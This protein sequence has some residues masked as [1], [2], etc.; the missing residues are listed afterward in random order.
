MGNST[1]PVTG[2]LSGRAWLCKLRSDKG[3]LIDVYVKLDVNT[4]LIRET[5][6]SR[7][8][9]ADWTVATAGVIIMQS[10]TIQLTVLSLKT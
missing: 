2:A 5:F 8:I 6:I 7:F 3:I 1:T 10:S 9:Y 4:V